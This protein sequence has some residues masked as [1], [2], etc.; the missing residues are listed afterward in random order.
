VKKKINQKR[1]LGRKRSQIARKKLEYEGPK[2]SIPVRWDLIRSK[3]H[4]N[5]FTDGYCTGEYVPNTSRKG[6]S[7]KKQSTQAKKVQRERGFGKRKRNS[8]KE[9][10]LQKKPR[11]TALRQLITRT[12]RTPKKGRKAW[13]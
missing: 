1:P 13:G 7:A 5:C 9:R 4:T 6:H 10:P 12:V 8:T 3:D 11:K 2:G